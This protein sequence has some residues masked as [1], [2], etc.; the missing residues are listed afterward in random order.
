LLWLGTDKLKSKN[1]YTKKYFVENNYFTTFVK[2]IKMG[3]FL[4]YLFV[5]LLSVKSYGQKVE[6]VL[7]QD[8]K[9]KITMMTSEELWM[10]VECITAIGK[11]KETLN[12]ASEDICNLIRKN[13]SHFNCQVVSIDSKKQRLNIRPQ[14]GETNLGSEK[15]V[16]IIKR[17]KKNSIINLLV[18]Y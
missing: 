12:W 14:K 3:K 2:K 1:N 18:L 10:Y 8:D 7:G 9:S 16:L 4:I 13:P 15:L 11:E 17:D 5:L 6:Y